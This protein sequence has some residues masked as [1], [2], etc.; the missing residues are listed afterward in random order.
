MHCVRIGDCR[1]Q[2]VQDRSLARGGQVE[3]IG[4]GQLRRPRCPSR[5]N[6]LSFASVSKSSSALPFV[7]LRG[8]GHTSTRA[9]LLR[10]VTF[11]LPL[12]TRS[13]SQK[14]YICMYRR[15]RSRR[16]MLS[17]KAEHVQRVG[18]CLFRPIGGLKWTRGAPRLT[19]RFCPQHRR[20][21]SSAF[22]KKARRPTS[23]MI[24]TLF[25]GVYP[26]SLPCLEGL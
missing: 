2:C 7:S 8:N 18:T 19:T 24:T 17:E 11:L 15:K 12:R 13:Y 10:R 23:I 21:R 1:L 6:G 3:C 4:P 26:V 5:M 14:R 9:W 25:N 22:L 20:E 16:K